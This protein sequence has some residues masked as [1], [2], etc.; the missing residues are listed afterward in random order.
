MQYTHL[1]MAYQKDLRTKIL[2]TKHLRGTYNV[3]T[4]QTF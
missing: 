2:V 1:S 3:N 4:N